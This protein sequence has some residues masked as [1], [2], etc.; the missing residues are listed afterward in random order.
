MANQQNQTP[1]KETY[2]YGEFFD[3]LQLKANQEK[4]GTK[5]ETA[6][7]TT[8]RLN[9]Y[10]RIGFFKGLSYFI[11][12]LLIAVFAVFDRKYGNRLEFYIIVFLIVFFEYN[13]KISK[14]AP[15]TQYANKMYKN[16]LIPFLVGFGVP[17]LLIPVSVYY[18]VKAL[19]ANNFAVNIITYDFYEPRKYN[20]FDYQNFAKVFLNYN[21]RILTAA[22]IVVAP[23]ITAGVLLFLYKYKTSPKNQ[24]KNK[25]ASKSTAAGINQ[26]ITNGYI[27]S[28]KYDVYN[29]LITGSTGSGKTNLVNQI[30]LDRKRFKMRSIIFDIKGDYLQT[31]YRPGK[32]I[33]WDITDAR[34]V[35]W[36]FLKEAEDKAQLK[37]FAY[38]LFE[39]IPGDNNPFFRSAAREMLF[40][41][42]LDIWM[43]DK[44][45]N[46]DFIQKINDINAGD[47]KKQNPD[48]INTYKD[49]I[50]NL[51]FVN[52]TGDEFKLKEWLRNPNDRRNIFVGVNLE[53][54]DIQRPFFRIFL[55]IINAMITGKS[56]SNTEHIRIYIDEF[57]N[58]GEIDNIDSALSLC[59]EQ[60]VGYTLS[61]QSLIN[62][63]AL[64]RNK[65]NNIIE[66]CNNIYNFKAKDSA[67]ARIISESYGMEDE[68]QML[69][70]QGSSSSN[71]S[72]SMTEN[73]RKEYIVK[74]KD[75]TELNP[76]QY[77]A[78]IMTD[79][80]SKLIQLHTLTFLPLKKDLTIEKFI[81]RT[82]WT[83]ESLQVLDAI[84]NDPKPAPGAEE[85]AQARKLDR[86][87]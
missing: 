86:G 37:Q 3:E 66:N 25:A 30:I 48:V 65:F 69:L 51:Q 33:L 62:I 10:R 32:D 11:P 58:I 8:H 80:G 19:R 15:N 57:G 2:N 13:Y 78:N 49:Q 42:L 5:I 12:F 46:D 20:F 16:Y 9:K 23:I 17:V 55:S 67:S 39:D 36:N 4:N 53:Y 74:V 56:W 22:E 82:D 44:T 61:T 26:E 1:S 79:A 38:Y 68:K 18:L 21:Y 73:L 70:S 50:A 41:K 27:H 75:L 59:R 72:V 31:F 71:Q 85:A 7:L 14:L 63:R 84:K 87:L 29:T 28:I 35:L 60:R 54:I 24:E 81:R 45:G 77:F 64:Y 6:N 47:V 76:G 52:T 40:S 83:K 43:A 34:S